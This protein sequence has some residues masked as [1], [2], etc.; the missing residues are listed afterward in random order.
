MMTPY[1]YPHRKLHHLFTYHAL[2]L[3]TTPVE[4][5][6]WGC[7]DKGAGTFVNCFGRYHRAKQYCQHPFDKFKDINGR[8]HTVHSESERIEGQLVKT[9]E[10]LRERD[11]GALLF[12]RDSSRIPEIPDNSVDLVITDPPYFDN[13]HYSELSNFF[14]VWL[15]LLIDDRTFQSETVPTEGEAVV[16]SGLKKDENSYQQLLTSVFKE[17]HRV[18]KE[19]G[20]FAFTFHH[21]KWHAWWTILCAVRNSGFQIVYSFPIM[22]EYKVSPHIRGKEALDSDLVVFC[23]YRKKPLKSVT[24]PNQ[25]IKR[26]LSSLDGKP[27]SILPNN[28]LLRYISELLKISTTNQTDYDWFKNAF[29]E[30]ATRM[31]Q[32]KKIK[33]N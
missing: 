10:D 4:N 11:R 31:E 25:L 13:I 1:N 6:V 16:N 22:S 21:S 18:L 7:D 8:V 29:Q 17:C 26:A 15:R 28:R 33:G 9:F 19:E 32:S 30:Y 20:I 2:P 3:T 5:V 23:K 12:C 24:N 27:S 14:Y